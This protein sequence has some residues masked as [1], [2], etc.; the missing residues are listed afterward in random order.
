MRAYIKSKLPSSYSSIKL[1]ECTY[2]T[3]DN[4]TPAKVVGRGEA[5]KESGCEHIGEWRCLAIAYMDAWSIPKRARKTLQ[6]TNCCDAW[7]NGT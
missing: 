2:Y 3:K 1:C 7:S 4:V 6:S 5:V